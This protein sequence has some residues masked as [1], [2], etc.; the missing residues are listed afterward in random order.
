[1]DLADDLVDLHPRRTAG[2]VSWFF[3]RRYSGLRQ[4]QCGSKHR[5]ISQ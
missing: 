3:I 2:A 1:M 4:S 5:P